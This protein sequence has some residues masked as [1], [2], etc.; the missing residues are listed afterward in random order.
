MRSQD[1]GIRGNISKVS[2]NDPFRSLDFEISYDIIIIRR[3]K[4][5]TDRK[6]SRFRHVYS[7]T[8][9]TIL[10]S[11][12][13]MIINFYRTSESEDLRTRRSKRPSI[14]KFHDS[15]MRESTI[16][17]IQES[18]DPRVQRRI[19]GSTNL[20]N[21]GIDGD[22]EYRNSICERSA[23]DASSRFP[24]LSLSLFF[25]NTVLDKRT[26]ICIL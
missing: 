19:R 9:G 6:S 22:G 16:P 2:I 12:I 14:R 4:D 24:F 17:G 15:R 10:E 11:D 18:E 26:H 3:S 23:C 8:S 20:C 21:S 25:L 7:R 1:L 5:L 13:N